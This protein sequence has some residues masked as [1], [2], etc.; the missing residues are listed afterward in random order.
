MKVLQINNVHYRRGGADAVYLNTADLLQNHGHEVVYFNMKKDMN[1]S[2][3]DEKYW[4]SSIESRPKGIKSTLLELRNFFYNPEAAEKIERLVKAEKPDI[5]HVHLFWGCGISPSITKVLKKYRIPLVQTV[6]DYRM[7]CPIALLM[8]RKGSVCERCKGKRFYKAG[9]FNCSHHG[10]IRSILM[11]AEMYY[12][13]MFFY[14]TDVVN[15]FVFVSNFAYKKHLQYMPRIK[16][17]NATV[18]YNFTVSDGEYSQ[19]SKEK[20]ILYYGRLSYEKGIRTLLEAMLLY[21]EMNVKVVGTGPIEEELKNNYNHSCTSGSISGAGKCYKNIQFLGYH[22]GGTLKELVRNAQFVCVPSECYEN[23]PMTIVEA[24][25]MGTPV[26]GA[27]IGG[28]PEIIEEG[29]TGYCFESGNVDDLNRV[30]MKATMMAE[31]DYLAM[32]HNSFTFYLNHFSAELHYEKL[33]AFYKHTLE[34]YER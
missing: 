10:R 26:I 18:L 33:I 8:D 1:I 5:A 17:A 19:N 25:S 6:H 9:V 13:N 16:E 11:A 30:I 2:C 31:N 3:K 29:K 22:S 15:G 21:P 4:V 20:Y 27:R 7:I 12:H 34:I 32:R 14:P 28:I 23:N 24:Y